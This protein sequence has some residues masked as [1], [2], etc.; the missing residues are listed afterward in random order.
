MGLVATNKWTIKLKNMTY[1]VG[2]KIDNKAFILVDK[3]VNDDPNESIDKLYHSITNNDIYISLTGDGELMDFIKEYDN[4]LKL[5][6]DKLEI[7]DKFIKKITTEFLNNYSVNISKKSSLYIID[8]SEFLR[9]DINFDNNKYVNHKNIKFSNNE[10]IY[11][12]S[13][14][15]EVFNDSGFTNIDIEG[16]FSTNIKNLYKIAS[17]L[18]NNGYKVDEY[19]INGFDYIEK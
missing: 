3:V 16:Y 17:N 12:D 18:S 7:S 4:N 19:F 9:I 2:G 10:W 14:E 8:N 11:C 15:K 5:K 6:N 1:I 13:K